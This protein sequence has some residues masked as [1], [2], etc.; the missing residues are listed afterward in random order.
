MAHFRVLLGQPE[1][2]V[3]PFI[4]MP[5]NLVILPD[6]TDLNHRCLSVHFDELELFVKHKCVLSPIKRSESSFD[7]F[8]R[9]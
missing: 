6:L 7:R 1:V 5:L 2:K 8:F 9:Y 3:W 4:P